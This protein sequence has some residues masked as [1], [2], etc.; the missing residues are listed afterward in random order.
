LQVVLYEGEAL[1]VLLRA[2]GWVIV[3]LDDT[4]AAPYF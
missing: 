4:A 2:R 1:W 3:P